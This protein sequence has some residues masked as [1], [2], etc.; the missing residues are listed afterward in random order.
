MPG[1]ASEKLKK[2]L[3]KLY[4]GLASAEREERVKICR[5]LLDYLLA[6]KEA[7]HGK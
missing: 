2:Y 7:D 6:K 4:I 1:S 5:W 3:A